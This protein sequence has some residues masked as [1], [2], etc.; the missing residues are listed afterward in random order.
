MGLNRT[1][2]LS[3][4]GFDGSEDNIIF[5]KELA[6]IANDIY[7]AG[8]LTEP[9]YEDCP[10]AQYVNWYDIIDDMKELSAFFPDV[11][12]V[13]DVEEGN[14]DKWTAL[15]NNGEMA[16]P[17]DRFKFYPEAAN[18]IVWDNVEI[19]PVWCRSE[20]DVCDVCDAG[21]ESMW[22]VYLHQ[23]SGG[24]VCIA[25][26]PSEKDAEDLMTLIKNLS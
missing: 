23:V 17:Q 18:G 14:G 2:T 8:F 21:K 11:V 6:D 7:D 15:F 3:V 9:N 16:Y 4:K 13:I 10:V 22:S 25:D 1:V 5:L 12:L 20:D 26:T 19:M 24:V